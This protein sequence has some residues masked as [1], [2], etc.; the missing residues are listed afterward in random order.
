MS[1]VARRRK[2]VLA[3]EIETRYLTQFRLDMELRNGKVLLQLSPEAMATQEATSATEK[4]KILGS[5]GA[6]QASSETP[7]PSL[8]QRA[9]AFTRGY[10]WLVLTC[11]VLIIAAGVLTF[12]QKSWNRLMLKL[13]GCVTFNWG[14]KAY[15]Y[16]EMQNVPQE[17][18]A[19]PL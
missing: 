12:P 14:G 5:F 17:N 10:F 3:I 4:D 19:I 13:F 7:K 16:C 9:Q 1:R 2:Q 15:R 11:A 18:G 8:Y 6:S